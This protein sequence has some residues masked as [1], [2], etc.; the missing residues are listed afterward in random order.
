MNNNVWIV[1]EGERGEGSSIMAVFSS[2][3]AAE[4][5]AEATWPEFGLTF[6]HDSGTR[7]ES[8]CDFVTVV[9]HRVR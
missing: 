9:E 1:S 8:G 7:Y 3:H 4:E 2:R 6:T 5:Y